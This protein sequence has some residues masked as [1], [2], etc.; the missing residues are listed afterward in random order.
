[1]S[2]ELAMM[3][4][5][6]PLQGG[7]MTSQEI[8]DH[9]KK[10]QGWSLQGGAIEK[11]F[12]FANYHETMAFVNAL[13]WIAHGQDHHPDLAVSYDRCVVRFNTHSVGGISINDFICAAKADALLQP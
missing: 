10:V 13:A 11:T 3:K 4:C 1:M 7:P 12:S 5:V 6:V 8:E 9:L 2:R